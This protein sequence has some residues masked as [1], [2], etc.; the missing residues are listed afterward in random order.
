LNVDVD[1]DVD[2]DADVDVDL[3]ELRERWPIRFL[4]PLCLLSLLQP[5]TKARLTLVRGLG[6]HVP[7]VA[8]L[9]RRSS[10]LRDGGI[11]DMVMGSPVTPVLRGVMLKGGYTPATRKR[12]TMST[13]MTGRTGSIACLLTRNKGVPHCG[14]PLSGTV[15]VV[16]I[17]Q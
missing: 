5:V 17:V 2:E 11:L 14:W 10:N 7:S 9:D 13:L 4:L 12:T 15:C 6:Q 3:R 8:V 1:V 16:L